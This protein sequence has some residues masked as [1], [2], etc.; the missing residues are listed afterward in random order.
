MRSVDLKP[1]KS[2]RIR[3]SDC[4]ANVM[5]S[6]QLNLAGKQGGEDCSVLGGSEPIRLSTTVR[7]LGV[8]SMA[9]TRS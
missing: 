2:S 9:L 8:G 3:L 7:D 5:H 6:Q 1:L 4:T